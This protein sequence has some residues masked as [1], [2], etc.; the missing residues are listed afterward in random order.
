M[1]FDGLD[2]LNGVGPRPPSDTPCINADLTVQAW[3]R[4]RGIHEIGR[5]INLDSARAI[6]RLH[7]GHND[8]IHFDSPITIARWP[9]L[10]IH[11]F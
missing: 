9:P 2:F 6:A 4:G 7:A 10:R 8:Y 1:R 3:T 11:E 5:G